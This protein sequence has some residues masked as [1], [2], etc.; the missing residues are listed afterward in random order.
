MLP[1]PLSIL[2]YCRFTVIPPA[3]C[4]DVV[5]ETLLQESRNGDREGLR[6]ENSHGDPK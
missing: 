4:S 2:F 1:L 3:N 6:G 5:L